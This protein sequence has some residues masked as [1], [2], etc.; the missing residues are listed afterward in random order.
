MRSF[1]YCALLVGFADCVSQLVARDFGA[2][3]ANSFANSSCDLQRVEGLTRSIASNAELCHLRMF[4]IRLEAMLCL[5][6]VGS[7]HGCANEALTRSG[8]SLH[9]RA[10]QLQVSRLLRGSFAS[11]QSL[12]PRARE[13]MTL[14]V[15]SRT[16]QWF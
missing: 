13:A 7:S 6:A 12:A 10:K 3:A 1:S 2:H 11:S 8:P 4:Y 9:A 15:P 14:G 16:Q 5:R